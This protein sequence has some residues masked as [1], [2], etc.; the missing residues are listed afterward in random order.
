ML[1]IGVIAPAGVGY[2]METVGSG[3]DDYYARTEPG[4]WIGAGTGALGLTGTV[5]ADQIDA[6]IAGFH[7]ET[8]E[9]LG[10]STTKVAAFDLTFSA[11]KSVSLLAELAGPDVRAETAAAHRQAV[12]ATLRFLED[13]HV[14][15]GRRG[16]AGARQIA[17][18]GA[19]AAAFDHRTSRAGDPA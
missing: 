2:Y 11:P 15:L 5:E 13:Q 17:T 9:P 6:L 12:Q 3:V 14:I 16:H 4:R 8:G 1:S 10:T 7:P 18:S 19:V